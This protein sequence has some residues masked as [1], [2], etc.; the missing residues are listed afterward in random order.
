MAWHRTVTGARPTGAL[1][2][3]P[4]S[5]RWSRLMSSHTQGMVKGRGGEGMGWEVWGRGRG[6]GWDG[7]PGAVGSRGWRAGGAAPGQKAQKPS[8]T[9]LASHNTLSRT[10]LSVCLWREWEAVVASSD[11]HTRFSCM[12]ILLP[13]GG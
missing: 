13:T 7:K 9:P 10:A 1:G 12:D 11:A 2:R 5:R 8:Q 4:D 6:K 3:L